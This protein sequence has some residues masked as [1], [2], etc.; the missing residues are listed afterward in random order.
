M[1][2]LPIALSAIFVAASVK[3]HFARSEI[4]VAEANHHHHD[5]LRHLQQSVDD[6]TNSVTEGPVTLEQL[7]L[8]QTIIQ[9][10]SNA[11]LPEGVDLTQVNVA[12]I[13]TQVLQE[14]DID[15]SAMSG[16]GTLNESEM[17][18]VVQEIIN[19]ASEILGVTTSTTA[20]ATTATT[21]T[22]AAVAAESCSVCGEGFEVGNPLGIL[23]LEEQPEVSCA[24]L[25]IAG[26]N[27]VI[28]S[29]QCA[30]LPEIITDICEC[31]PSSSATTTIIP[32]TT[33]D[34]T[35]ATTPSC[36]CSPLSYTFTINFSKT[37]ETNTIA[38]NPGIENAICQINT[39]PPNDDSVDFSTL[40]VFD[41]QFLEVDTSGDLSVINQV[42]RFNV[43]LSDGDTITFDSVAAKLNPNV[44]LAD[45]LNY[46]PG[47][48]LLALR[49]RSDGSTAIV[50]NR[51]T[52]TYTNSCES[53][54]L[55]VGDAIDWV[56]LV[57][58]RYDL[59]IERLLL[60]FQQ[61]F[62]LI[63]LSVHV[64]LLMTCT[65]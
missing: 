5:L 7:Q 16:G 38:G 10:L 40:K 55:S 50:T 2:S 44:P 59:W 30:A 24:A 9:E 49:A 26:E 28:P 46:V 3:P 57:S 1:R 20:K 36:V 15:A 35:T 22:T 23:S 64:C 42:D 8:V 39:V 31:I 53:L 19:K 56:T 18:S 6:M 41:V 25:Q 61:F 37:C 60:L 13:I 32:T 4:A 65:D 52:W 17:S 33:T 11:T 29:E 27:G 43:S 54:P 34:A 62:D 63:I 21:T 58:E 14:L 47:G 45:Q 48:V 12:V 51:P